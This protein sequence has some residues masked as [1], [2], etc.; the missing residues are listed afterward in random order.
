MTSDEISNLS[1]LLISVNRFCAVYLPGHYEKFFSIRK[2][3]FLILTIWITSIVGCIILYELIGCNLYYDKSSWTL[4]FI[5]T[6]KC[7][8][9]TWYSD[10]GFNISLVVLTLVT[11][12]LTAFKARR[13]SQTLMNAAGIKMS[14]TQ[15]Q[16]ELNFIR[17]TFF[18]GLSVATGQITYYLIAP[19]LTNPVITFVVG[20][21]WGFMHAVEG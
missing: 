20:T 7:V 10:F 14:K 15:K 9:L 3:K 12:L 11:N 4:A 17:Q 21:L 19:I 18:Q 8:Q 13:N 5:Q 6:K 2:T 1:H 16:R